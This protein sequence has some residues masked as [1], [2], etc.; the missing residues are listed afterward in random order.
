MFH[1]LPLTAEVVQGELRICV[2]VDTLAF[3][4]D[5]ETRWTRLREKVEAT[6]RSTLLSF[7][8]RRAELLE[9]VAGERDEDEFVGGLLSIDNLDFETQK[10]ATLEVLKKTDELRRAYAVFDAVRS[11]PIWM[12][13]FE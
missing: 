10:E 8:L 3:V 6:E 9:L 13:G 1:K 12:R 5:L 11:F 7:C 4:V 2:G